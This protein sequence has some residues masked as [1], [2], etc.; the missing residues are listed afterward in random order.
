M[1][2]GAVTTRVPPGGVKTGALGVVM[3]VTREANS[4]WFGFDASERW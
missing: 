3:E 1:A 2:G 4:G